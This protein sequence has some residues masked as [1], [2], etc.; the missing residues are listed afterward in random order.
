MAGNVVLFTP[1][2]TEAAV[3]ATVARTLLPGGRLVAGFS[4]QPD[5][6]DLASYDRDCAAAG[7]TLEARWSTWEQAPFAG[8]GDYAVSVHRAPHRPTATSG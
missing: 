8:D 6:Y 2:G 3:V 5:T 7:L 4:L 1:P